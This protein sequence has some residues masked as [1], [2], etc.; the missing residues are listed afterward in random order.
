VARGFRRSA[1]YRSDQLYVV[2]R[3]FDRVFVSENARNRGRHYGLTL[4]V[5]LRELQSV[6][7]LQE[8]R[9]GR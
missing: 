8:A 6:D 1:A 9:P 4:E 3:L 5:G 7:V 2:D